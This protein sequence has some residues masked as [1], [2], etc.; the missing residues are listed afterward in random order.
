MNKTNDSGLGELIS[1]YR[2]APSPNILYEVVYREKHT[3]SD[4]KAGDVVKMLC[5]PDGSNVFFRVVDCTLH[6]ILFDG[7]YVMLRKVEVSE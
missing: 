1:A 5:D 7:Q 4:L 3:K 2:V 6:P